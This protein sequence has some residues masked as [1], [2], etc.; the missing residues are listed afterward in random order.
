[1][2]HRSRLPTVD[3]NFF[4]HFLQQQSGKRETIQ[5]VG[6][7][8]RTSHRYTPSTVVKGRYVRLSFE[9][10]SA[11]M[12][13]NTRRTTGVPINTSTRTGHSLERNPTC[14]VRKSTHTHTHIIYAY[15]HTSVYTHTVF[16]VYRKFK[17]S[18]NF[19]LRSS[20]VT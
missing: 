18:D 4:P 15:S 20:E 6:R 14:H 16:T 1:M 5:H 8:S 19:H 17:L 13:T 2:F 10:V 12:W 7:R 3:W 11:Q 9:V